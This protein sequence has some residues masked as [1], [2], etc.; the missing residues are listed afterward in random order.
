MAFITTQECWIREFYCFLRELIYVL[1]ICH[2]IIFLWQAFWHCLN[3]YKKKWVNIDKILDS[4][5]R[6]D[7]K[8]WKEAYHTYPL[9]NFQFGKLF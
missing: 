1:P 6:L 9:L 8:K 7:H 3:T 2:V 4:Q 5:M